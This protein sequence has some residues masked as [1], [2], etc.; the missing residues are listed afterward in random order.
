MTL[1]P[2]V[3][4]ALLTA[5]RAPE[6]ARSRRRRG[7]RVLGPAV[8][9]ALA[10]LAVAVAV[11]AL[12]LLSGRHAAQAPAHGPS[13]A[14]QV[15]ST[16]QTLLATLGVLRS[17]QSGPNVTIHQLPLGSSRGPFGGKV[18]RSLVRT[19]SLA[20]SR[21]AAALLP[22][23]MAAARAAPASEQLVVVVANRPPRQHGHGAGGLEPRQWSSPVTVAQLRSHGMLVLTSPRNWGAMVVPDGVT[24]VQVGP[25]VSL[26]PPPNDPQL[27]HQITLPRQITP[28]SADVSDNVAPIELG[29]V[30]GR[31]T[32]PHKS[33]FLAVPVRLQTTWFAGD[34]RI[35][36]QPKVNAVM[37]VTMGPPAR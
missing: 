4:H 36:A 29:P 24:E 10:C 37:W 11:G 16:R 28:C 21:A 6:P 31:M 3:E 19:V 13:G 33:R 22:V 30:H 35:V 9:V 32:S 25:G 2:E 20:G 7:Q 5:I 34:G 17:P 14:G 27:G 23:R 26:R 15:P 18:D 1:L 8:T 12:L